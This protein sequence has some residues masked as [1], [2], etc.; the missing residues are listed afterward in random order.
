[1]VTSAGHMTKGLIAKLRG[2]NIL[3][4]KFFMKALFLNIPLV[5]TIDLFNYKSIIVARSI[6]PFVVVPELTCI[7]S[8]MGYVM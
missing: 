1:M 5:N 6:T 3:F 2:H 7:V 4:S 8:V